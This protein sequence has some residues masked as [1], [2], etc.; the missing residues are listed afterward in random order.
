MNFRDVARHLSKRCLVLLG[1]V[2]PG[3][4]EARE[5][6]ASDAW[7]VYVSRKTPESF[8]TVSEGTASEFKGVESYF[9]IVTRYVWYSRSATQGEWNKEWEADVHVTRQGIYIIGN[10][11]DHA[12]KCLEVAYKKLW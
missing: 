2:R 5:K 3:S 9:F 8:V 6:W 11:P 4:I 12:A 7:D 1:A 10:M